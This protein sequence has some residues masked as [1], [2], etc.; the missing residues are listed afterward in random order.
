MK[1]IITV[2]HKTLRTVATDL[3]KSSGSSFLMQ[4]LQNAL[5]NS[6]PKGA[7]LALPQ[8]DSSFRGFSVFLSAEENA[9]DTTRPSSRKQDVQMKSF[10]NPKIVDVPSEKTFGPDSEDPILEGCLS[11]PT[12]YG[13]VPRFAWLRLSY[14]DLNFTAHEETFYGFYAR[15]IQHE[16][17]HLEGILFTDYSLRLELPLYQLDNGKMNSIPLDIVKTW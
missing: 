5:R 17:D 10:I 4:E 16:Y 3:Q 15:V 14:L 9:L 8:I 1:K 2:P 6:N 11:I 12:I 7:G 13:P